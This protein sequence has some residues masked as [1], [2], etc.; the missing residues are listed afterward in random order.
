MSK[1]DSKCPSPPTPDGTIPSRD[2]SICQ[3][4][5]DVQT[6]SEPASVDNQPTDD[7]G[8]SEMSMD[9][10]TKTVDNSFE[11]D[12]KWYNEPPA[13]DDATGNLGQFE[14]EKDESEQIDISVGAKQYAG[15]GFKPLDPNWRGKITPVDEALI[16]DI[17]C[18]FDDQ[19]QPRPRLTQRQAEIN[20]KKAQGY[21]SK[22]W[23]WWYDLGIVAPVPFGRGQLNANPEAYPWAK[24]K[25]HVLHHIYI[26]MLVFKRSR[27][28]YRSYWLPRWKIVKGIQGAPDHWEITNM[29]GDALTKIA[30]QWAITNDPSQPDPSQFRPKASSRKIGFWIRGWGVDQADAEQN[31][32]DKARI[33]HHMFVN[34]LQ[35]DLIMSV[36]PEETYKSSLT[37]DA[38][39]GIDDTP[40]KG[41]LHGKGFVGG[42]LL[43]KMA[44]ALKEQLPIVTKAMETTSKNYAKVAKKQDELYVLIARQTDAALMKAKLDEINE[45]NVDVQLA[46][47]RSRLA[48]MEPVMDQIKP[49]LSKL[50]DEMERLAPA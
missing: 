28:M 20:H 1:V 36:S 35:L 29:P 2:D 37:Q 33:I 4:E 11:F 45:K 43:D 8:H 38:L 44:D 14:Q 10:S 26:S 40:Y 15:T 24:P 31:A 16:K 30:W 23:P 49:T 22:N 5:N 17:C 34:A 7:L 50:V 3:D 21:I 19:G 32:W 39:L 13:N 46:D 41:T 27:D 48:R 18:D 9:N 47:I 12:E 42:E 6:Q 25:K